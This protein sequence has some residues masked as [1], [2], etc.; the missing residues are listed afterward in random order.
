MAAPPPHH[1][2][3]PHRPSHRSSDS[4]T[5]KETIESIIIALV[6]AFVFRAFVVEAFVIPTGSMAPTLL[7]QHMQLVSPESG[8]KFTA[9]PSMVISPNKTMTEQTVRGI[10]PMSGSDILLR[11]GTRVNAGDRILVQKYIYNFF[12]PR[13]WDVVVFKNPEDPAV[14]YIKRLVGLPGETL[15]I[16]E[17]NLYVK[18]PDGPWRIAR[19][20][21]T[22]EN[23]RAMKVQRTV[24]Q[25]IHRTQYTAYDSTESPW[26]TKAGDWQSQGY[27]GFV[28]NSPSSVDDPAVLQ[29]DLHQVLN[30]RPE[31]SPY[32]YPYNHLSTQNLQPEPIEDVRLLVAVELMTSSHT[33]GK[34]GGHVGGNAGGNVGGVRLSTTARLDTHPDRPVTLSAVIDPTGRAR[35]EAID[36]E[37]AQPLARVLA[38]T[39]IDALSVGQTSVLELWYVDQEASL[40]VDGKQV[41]RW[42]FELDIDTLRERLP[43]VHNT[44]QQDPD[45]Q[46]PI[47]R[48]EISDATAKVH[49]VE[50]DRDLFYSTLFSDGHQSRGTLAKGIH[51]YQRGGEEAARARQEPL[52]LGEDEFFCLGDNSPRSKDGRLWDTLNPWIQHRQFDG[53]LRLGVVPRD[54]MIGRAFCV[55][56][57]APYRWSP[58]SRGVIPNFGKMRF[59][60]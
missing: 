32:Q 55:Y 52:V 5:I 28:L 25:P 21:D 7:G 45:K 8:Y 57:P 35:L 37:S 3:P 27:R 43:M 15:W 13:R 22:S 49:R 9:D 2:R 40:W 16:I 29:F 41:L 1:P 50:V 51:L 46:Q 60:H 4:D 17:G 31:V 30:P 39:R 6:L 11:P 53:E 12:E 38:E 14:N 36:H 42:G 58:S 44:H 26:K 20:T 33:G 10:D 34:A 23:H 48:V 24:W 47:L 59:I 18:Q 56:W 54:M 19:K